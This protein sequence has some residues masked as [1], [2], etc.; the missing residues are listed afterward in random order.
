MEKKTAKQQGSNSSESP[1]IEGYRIVERLGKG[2][3]GSVYKA[4]KN[5]KTYALKMIS[6]S[7][8]KDRPFLRKYIEHETDSMKSI[9]CVNCVRLFD[10]FETN[11]AHFFVLEFCAEGNLF[12]L[13]HSK[14]G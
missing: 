12:N 10:Y 6:K 13:L 8:M 14:N 2:S 4:E 9:N 5:G 7:Y 11:L 1:I 3:F